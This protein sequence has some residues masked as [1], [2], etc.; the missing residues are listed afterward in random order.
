MEE[1]YPN[2]LKK[3]EN[4]EHSIVPSMEF[5]D[6]LLRKCARELGIEDDPEEEKK[7]HFYQKSKKK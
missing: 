1:I 5:V 3:D 6:N 7:S 2:F 4:K